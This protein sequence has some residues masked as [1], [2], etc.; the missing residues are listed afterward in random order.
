MKLW[1]HHH[2]ITTAISSARRKL[3]H[4]TIIIYLVCSIPVSSIAQGKLPV[5]LPTIGQ[6]V[7]QLF[8]I[9]EKK[10]FKKHNDSSDA[11]SRT[12]HGIHLFGKNK[13]TFAST[14][15]DT[16]GMPVE[17]SITPNVDISTLNKSPHPSV[18]IFGYH[19]YW[20]SQSPDAYI[21]EYL[22]T[23]AYFAYQVNPEDGSMTNL[24]KNSS[25]AALKNAAGK[26]VVTI[27]NIGASQNKTFLGN[28]AA[29]G[30]LINSLVQLVGQQKLNG[31]S[32]DF[33][34]VP[35]AN[36]TD[37]T[38]FIK[39][40]ATALH[41]QDKDL[42]V[43]IAIPALDPE[44]IFDVGALASYVD[45]FIIMAYDY[46]W[47]GSTVAGP[48]SP[49]ISNT[50]WPRNMNITYAIAKF[51]ARQAPPAKILLG[52]PY[53]GT[54]WQTK[55]LNYPSDKLSYNSLT[56]YQIKQLLGNN[57]SSFDQ[58][59]LTEYYTYTKDG[60]DYQ[61]WFDGPKSLSEKY[62]FVIRNHLGGIAIW[63][64]GYDRNSKELWQTL[65]NNFDTT[66]VETIRIQSPADTMMLAA[67][68]SAAASRDSSLIIA[69]NVTTDS[70]ATSNIPSGNILK[71]IGVTGMKQVALAGLL[72][73]GNFFLLGFVVAMA[74]KKLE[75]LLKDKLAVVHIVFALL[76][77]GVIILL[78]TTQGINNGWQMFGFG[79]AGGLLIGSIIKIGVKSRK[80]LP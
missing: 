10:I 38:A 7:I 64:L 45:Y 72:I 5:T 49:L 39:A 75:T 32:V 18:E 28:T 47:R 63:C 22:T 25:P 50:P 71:L 74:N 14:A 62:Q 80:E 2:A 19:P 1:I 67:I 20:I 30:K 69:N 16:A 35:H 24:D 11:A 66:Q 78:L 56:Y 23:I 13:K 6:K 48:N 61:V 58:E 12:H 55:G 26:A 36:R 17:D 15:V 68:S 54:Q 76:L 77:I 40:L 43:S 51:I 33:E 73:L 60:K 79:A 27:I 21:K 59:S 52:V 3:F 57:Q 70:T 41:Q 53:Y 31:V 65:V 37:Y 42:Q 4:I 44:E 46:Y 29:Q 9:L 34:E 8:G